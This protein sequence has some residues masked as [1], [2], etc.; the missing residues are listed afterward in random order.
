M[1]A[2]DWFPMKKIERQLLLY[3]IF[4]HNY[5]VQYDTVKYW[6]KMKDSQLRTF[7]RDLKELNDSGLI[8]TYYDYD[9]RAYVNKGATEISQNAK[10]RYLEHLIRLNRV[11]RCMT[12]LWQDDV[13]EPTLEWQVEDRKSWSE[14]FYEDE[15]IDVTTLHSCKDTYKELFPRV[16]DRT[17]QRDFKL[18]NQIG[19]TIW[20]NPK[21]HYYH[22]NF[23]EQEDLPVDVRNNDGRLEMYVECLQM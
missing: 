4:L 6:L 21:I 20:F 16:G 9:E 18:L 13:D 22:M 23:P 17:M 3:H 15:Y 19:Y 8:S 14:S 7:Y 2:G 11:G 12:E 5:C 10:G 1:S